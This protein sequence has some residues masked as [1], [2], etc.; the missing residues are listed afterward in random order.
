MSEL[1]A[2]SKEPLW[3]QIRRCLKTA[4]LQG[5][6]PPGTRLPTEHQLAAQFSV[7]R[8]TLRRAVASLV[9]AGLL[10]AQQGRGIFVQEN[11]LFYPIGKRTR[12]T[13]SVE[14]QNRSRGR[15]ILSAEEQ[16]A[17]AAVAAA[18]G[19]LQG[20]PVIQLR[21]LQQVDGRPVSLAEDYFNKAQLPRISEFALQTLSIT[22]SLRLCGVTDY[23]RKRTV[24]TTRLPKREEAEAL[25]Q[26]PSRPIL[27]TESLDVDINERPVAF[28][29][30]LWAGDRVQLAFEP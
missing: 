11:V 23:F 7:N 10:Q 26:P 15:H 14:R 9:D 21:S 5:E 19:M 28:G 22:E 25:Q 20:R 29:Y 6:Y 3:R 13:A 30:T 12:F 16:Q 17:D 2:T 27:V 1:D 8:H 24:V 4:I 18:L